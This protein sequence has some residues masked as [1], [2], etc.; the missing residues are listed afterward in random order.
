[1]ASQFTAKTTNS[2]KKLSIFVIYVLINKQTEVSCVIHMHKSQILRRKNF[3]APVN[4]GRE[5]MAPP[6]PFSMALF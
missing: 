5:E 3:F 6:P 1:M 2:E 4:G